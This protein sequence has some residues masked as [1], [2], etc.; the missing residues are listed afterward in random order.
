MLSAPPRIPLPPTVIDQTTLGHRLLKEHLDAVPHVGWQV[1]PFGH[2]A[3]QAALLSAEV[4]FDALYFGRL[5]YEDRARRLAT[6]AAEW[7]WRPSPSLGADAQVFSGLTG[8][9]SGNYGPPAGFCWDVKCSD[10]PMQDDPSLDGYNVQSR[11]ADFVR[12]ARS[13]ANVT[14]GAHLLFTMGSDYQYEAAE[15]WFTNLDK[16]VTHV[17]AQSAH[18]GVSASYSSMD[19][20]VAAKRNDKSVAAWPLKTDD[21]LPYADGPH[22]RAPHH[23]TAS[24]PLLLPAPFARL[25]S[26]RTHTHVPVPQAASAL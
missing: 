16:L 21:F 20:Y 6:K 12:A 13:Q 5:D 24:P 3:A 26:P 10:E 11:V 25:A 7:V 2:T 9:Y 14:R 23:P 18:T 17:N 4:G 1:D 15:E 19:T 8:S 22:V